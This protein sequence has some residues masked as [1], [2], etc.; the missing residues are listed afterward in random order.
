MSKNPT[1]A[2]EKAAMLR[3]KI[4]MREKQLQDL[5]ETVTEFNERLNQVETPKFK[6]F[7]NDKRLYCKIESMMPRIGSSQRN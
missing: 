7:L 2:D 3:E 5:A 4:A 1:E 6:L